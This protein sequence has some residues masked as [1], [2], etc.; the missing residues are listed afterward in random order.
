VLDHLAPARRRVVVASMGVLVAA[1]VVVGIVVALPHVHHHRSG[2]HPVSQDAQPPILLVPGYG[3]GTAGL[4]V[5]AAAL[6]RT[7]RQVSIVRLAG[8]G[9]GDLNLQADVLE[10]AVRKAVKAGIGSVDLVG[11]SAGGVTVRLWARQYDGGAVARRI[12]TLGSPQHGTDLAAL[13]N[14]VL[15]DRCPLAC[16]QLATGSQLISQ[17]NSGDETPPG[18]MWVSIWTRDDE[19]ST[20]P[21]T[22]KLTGALDFAVQQVC[23]GAQVSH[24]QLPASP[25]VIAMVEAQLRRTP[26]AV[27]GP[28][29]CRAA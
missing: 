27:P 26:P 22:A 4:Q 3:G 7:G 20:P 2:L 16:Q 14:D 11:Y 28:S 10:D 23:P 24:D 6:R 5:M 17:L 13:A 9:T 29:V 1:V 8:D 15:P 21:Q 25:V 12:V 18:P 19:V